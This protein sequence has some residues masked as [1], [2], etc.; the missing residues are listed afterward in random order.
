VAGKC[1]NCGARV[2]ELST[3]SDGR[4]VCCEH[5]VFNPLGCRCCYGDFDEPQQLG[6]WMEDEED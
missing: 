4:L 2:P 6:P 1:D 5:C 3:C